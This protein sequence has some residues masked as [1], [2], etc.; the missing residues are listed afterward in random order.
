MLV[1]GLVV[2]ARGRLG[3]V[4]REHS[5]ASAPK[6]NHMVPDC[7]SRPLGAVGRE[8]VASSAGPG[9]RAATCG[10]R[11]RSGGTV[12]IGGAVQ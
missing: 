2:V 3:G 9:S 12:L 6:V 4:A 8:W 10:R 11:V 5:P 7:T 1:P